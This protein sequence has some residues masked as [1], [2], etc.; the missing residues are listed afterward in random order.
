MTLQDV[1]NGLTG[2]SWLTEPQ[3]LLHCR[4]HVTLTK[5]E[6]KQLHEEA[7]VALGKGDSLAAS[8]RLYAGLVLDEPR[9]LARLQKDG[10]LRVSRYS[11]QQEPVAPVVTALLGPG[12][13][14]SATTVAYLESVSNLH[15]VAKSVRALYDLLREWL[16]DEREMGI[17]STLA[18]IDFLF[19]RQVAGFRLGDKTQTS[20]DARFF[21]IEELAEGF[22]ALLALYGNEFG[23]LRGNV[24]I[25][26]EASCEGFYYGMLTAAAHVAAFREWEFQI[27]RM[28][29]QLTR[30]P[31]STVFSLRHPDFE[32]HRAVELGYIQTIQQGLIK[33]REWIDLDAH[34]FEEMGSRLLAIL[35]KH[36]HIKHLLEPVERYRIELPEPM[37]SSTAEIGEFLRE[38]RLYLMGTCRDL[39]TPLDQLLPFALGNGLTLQD[40][41]YASRLMHVI[42]SINAAKLLPEAATRP[43]VVFQSLVPAFDRDRLIGLVGTVIG[44]DKAEAAIAM[45]TVDITKH[46]DVQYQPLIPFG[47]A[48]LLPANVFANSNIYRNPLVVTRVRLYEDGRIDP[49]GDSLTSAFK[50]AGAV[51][52]SR[53]VYSWKGERGEIDVLV[54]IGSFLFAFECKNSLLP[55]GMHELMTS[56]D[57]VRTAADQLDRFKKHFEDPA[58][59]SWLV[60]ETACPIDANTRLV[61]GIV[62]S[63]RMFM[64]LRVNGHPVRGNY[65]L[66]HFVAD[67]TV[68]MADESRSFWLGTTFTGEDLRRFLEEDVTYR[69]QWNAMTRF[70]ARYVWDDCTVE[71]ERVSQS[72]LALAEELGFERAKATI[73]EQQAAFEKEHADTDHPDGSDEASDE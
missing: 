69:P 35:E 60:K 37:L 1:L 3:R 28:G 20:R 8:N 42:R 7:S 22:S 9:F 15:R 61:T 36:G 58:F 49:L 68:S 2:P 33:S 52:K 26:P 44:R 27:D 18:A 10:I 64:G 54:M 45:M 59:R 53:L 39:L 6:S 17:K 13:G 14:L 46:V 25:N 29:Y 12:L 4:G 62:M 23:E 21:T 38:E 24:S 5:A 11:Y 47:K 71:V 50:A 66:E 34:S 72:M 40:L 70:T 32:F 55:C 30:D 67:G 16:V 41:F 63:N 31:T 73:L 19:L 48:I 57:Y 56:L 43:G 65:E 51:T